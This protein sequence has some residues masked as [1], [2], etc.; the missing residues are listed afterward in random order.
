MSDISGVVIPLPMY[1]QISKSLLQSVT[2][3]T[4]QI[5]Y[6]LSVIA[7]TE[8]QL[9]TIYYVKPASSSLK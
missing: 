1:L 5:E 2:P 3:K 6:N 4:P 8:K 7:E 9:N